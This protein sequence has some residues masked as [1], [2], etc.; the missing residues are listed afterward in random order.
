MQKLLK[1]VF[2]LAAISGWL[3]FYFPTLKII[4]KDKLFTQKIC[5]SPVTY[6]I[7]SVDIGFKISEKEVSDA[8]TEAVSIWEEARNT[9]LFNQVDSGADIKVILKFDDRQKITNSL[10]G[11]NGTIEVENSQIEVQRINYKALESQ[12]N[13]AKSEYEYSLQKYYAMRGA[14]NQSLQRAEQELRSDQQRLEQLRNELN[15][16]AG[17]LNSQVSSLNTKINSFNSLEQQRGERFNEGEYVEDK[18]TRTIYVYEFEDREKLVRLLA[19]EFGHA[20]GLEH[21]AGAKSIMNEI[22]G[23]SSI[24]LSSQDLAE[25]NRVCSSSNNT[26]STE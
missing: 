26:I 16:Y 10:G 18:G 21:V 14:D 25:L 9:D 6:S 22:N 19:H 2:T 1:I 15:N 11:L 24:V 12:Y 20:L 23:S 3:Y 17:T 7:E 13:K 4:Y 5:S 8:L